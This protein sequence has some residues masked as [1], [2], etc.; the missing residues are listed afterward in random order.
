MRVPGESVLIWK[1]EHSDPRRR[2][3]G[4]ARR[5]LANPMERP[6]A[7]AAVVFRFAH[8]R[9]LGAFGGRMEAKVAAID[10]IQSEATLG[11]VVVCDVEFEADVV[12]D[13]EHF[14]E[15]SVVPPRPG[16]DRNC[17]RDC[18]A[19]QQTP[20]A[21]GVVT[22]PKIGEPRGDDRE[23][24]RIEKREK[25]DPDADRARG[26]DAVQG[27]GPACPEAEKHQPRRDV[28]D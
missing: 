27:A 28:H 20:P 24:R 26:Q 8:S 10:L 1:P 19:T 16:R 2:E 3:A 18:D 17:R 7:S 5:M 13:E 23:R 14:T 4:E 12:T 15:L 21:G 25:P 6:D 11:E 22:P 9:P